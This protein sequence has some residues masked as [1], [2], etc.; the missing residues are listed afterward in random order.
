MVSIEVSPSVVV[1]W[2]TSVVRLR[3]VTLEGNPPQLALTKWYVNGQLV[4]TTYES[5]AD[6]TADQLV[7]TNVSRTQAGN[8]SCQGY[9]GAANASR[10]S[11]AKPLVV[12]CMTNKLINSMTISALALPSPPLPPPSGPLSHQY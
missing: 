3:C 8:Y 7:L 5:Q 9:N 4:D 10:L 6:G 1:E 11:A 12:H 2:S